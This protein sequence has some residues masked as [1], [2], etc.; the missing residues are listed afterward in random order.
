M[1]LFSMNNQANN[2][3]VGQKIFLVLLPRDHFMG[4]EKQKKPDEFKSALA[5]AESIMAA[6]GGLKRSSMFGNLLGSSAPDQVSFE[7]VADKGKISFYL[8][9]PN[10]LVNYMT[11]QIRSALEGVEIQEIEDYNIFKPTGRMQGIYIKLSKASYLPI[12]TYQAFDTDPLESITNVL[13]KL[14]QNESAALQ[15][16]VRSA[17]SSWHV[18][19]KQAASRIKKGEEL[20]DDSGNLSKKIITGAGKVLKESVTGKKSEDEEKDDDKPVRLS[21][22]EEEMAKMIEDKNSKAG[23]E[24]NIRLLVTG[25]EESSI[26]ASLESI[27]NSFAQYNIYEY[28]NELKSVTENK[29]H[30][31]KDFIFRS[32][33]TSKKAILNT[34]ELI[35]LFHFPL[36]STTTPNIKWLTSRKAPAPVNMPVEGLILGKNTFRN[37]EKDVHMLED[38]RR[39]HVYI[40]GTTGV[41]KTVLSQNMAL[42]DI[43][44]GHGVGVIDPHGDFVEYLLA[45]IPENRYEDV[46][47][48]DPANTDYPVGLNMLEAKDAQAKDFVTQEMIQIFYKLVPNPEM[49]GPMFEHNMR[50]AM[51]TLMADS[52]NLGTIAEIPR[53]FSDTE[54]QKALVAKLDD[55]VVRAF[56]E[57][58][59]A[60]TSDFHKSEM[61]GYLISKVGRFVENEMMRNIIGQAKSGIDFKQVISDKKILLVNLSKG[62]VGEIN[63]SLLGLIVVSKL[64]MAAF[65]QAKLDQADRKDFYLYIDE[66]QNYTTDSIATILSEARKYKLNLTMAHQY[67]GQLVQGQDSSIRDAVLGN[68]GTMISFRIGVE[69]APTIA[70]QM[71]P[72]FGEYDLVNLE[73]FN[74]CVKMLIN[75]TV[76]RAFSMQT[77]P[78]RE[79]DPRKKQLLKELSARKYGRPK[80]EVMAE[81]L[82]RSKLGEVAK[83]ADTSDVERSL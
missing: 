58:E 53:I 66:F 57:K 50:N 38:D 15:F 80:A 19:G 42:Q 40:V 77:Y 6:I 25:T 34:E 71:A 36:A 21:P 28:G 27:A 47:L 55:P 72:V 13:S 22:K 14:S 60:K 16:I 81:I 18:A 63:S 68:V 48:F 82:E 70:A 9:V 30:F 44:A 74:A 12:K 62:L 1:S 37:E 79:G 29:N 5:K 39:R 24:V 20:Y 61:L 11:Q 46:I 23:L 32:Y 43:E 73:R 78:P 35:S 8:A 64:Q 49:M 67:L 10:K 45:N 59:M 3:S 69:D 33:K 4:E 76:E 2:P 31:V 26:K 52:E 75:N 54:F 17:P 83:K 65:D 51:L 7:I 41:G 56:W